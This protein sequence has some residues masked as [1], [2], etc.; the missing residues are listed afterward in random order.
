M[1]DIID[2]TEDETDQR[3][4]SISASQQEDAIKTQNISLQTPQQNCL[5]AVE[6]P[7]VV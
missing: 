5:I 7:I 4:H 2:G 6:N 1:I 3:R